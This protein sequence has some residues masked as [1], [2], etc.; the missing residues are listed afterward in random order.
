[1]SKQAKPAKTPTKSDHI[2]E[3]KKANDKGKGPSTTESYPGP[4][5]SGGSQ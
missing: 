4:K 5:P 1:M 3:N 2:E